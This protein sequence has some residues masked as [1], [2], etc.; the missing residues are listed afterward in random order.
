M[1]DIIL[2]AR[3]LEIKRIASERYGESEVVQIIPAVA[4]NESFIAE[5]RELGVKDH[6]N[7]DETEEVKEV[8]D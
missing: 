1:A 7:K 3:D 4:F 8:D 5:M 2:K 6:R